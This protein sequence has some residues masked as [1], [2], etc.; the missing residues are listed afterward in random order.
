MANNSLLF[1]DKPCFF[2]PE[3]GLFFAPQYSLSSI[4][5]KAVDAYG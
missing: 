4:Y 2:L 1:V 5:L 3:V